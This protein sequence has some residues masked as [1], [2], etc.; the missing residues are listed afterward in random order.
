MPKRGDEYQEI[1]GAVA[2]AL[3]PGATVNVGQWVEGPDG[4]RDM[5]VEVK[6]TIEGRPRF[7]LIECKD[8]R[9]PVGIKEIDALDSKRHDL[10]SDETIIYSNSGFTGDALR[11]A[12]RVRIGACSVLKAKDKL[13]KLAFYRE[14]VAKKISVDRW[15]PVLYFAK[16]NPQRLENGWDVS[17]L[18]YKGSAVVNWISRISY[19][20]LKRHEDCKEV[21]ANFAFGQEV[22]FTLGDSVLKL[23]GIGFRLECSKKW[24]SQEVQVDITLG[25]FDHLRNK[26]VIP[27]K[28]TYILGWIDPNA[29]TEI[30][31]PGWKPPE[32]GSFELYLTLF[33]PVKEV[34]TKETPELDAII[35]ERE[36]KCSNSSSK[37]PLQPEFHQRLG[38]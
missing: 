24:V 32:K 7:V 34:E 18:L 3:D 16:N 20:I 13:I 12:R 5:D 10:G 21:V 27:D 25:I 2:K 6:G 14:L 22:K 8:W 36:E 4:R 23:T 28:E 17:S 26:I 15:S 35:I 1:V 30:D 19:D 31:Y 11:K 29:W 37:H 9:R 38:R 33:N